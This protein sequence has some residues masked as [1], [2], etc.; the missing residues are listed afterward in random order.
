MPAGFSRERPKQSRVSSKVLSPRP[1]GDLRPH[2]SL[3][4]SEGDGLLVAPRDGDVC[5]LRRLVRLNGKARSIF[6]ALARG[7]RD[8]DVPSELWDDFARHGL[9]EASGQAI[10]AGLPEALG[11][12][13]HGERRLPARD[14][15][16]ASRAILAS[17]ARLRL[18]VLGRSMRPAL[19]NGS[20]IEVSATRPERLRRGDVLFYEKEEHP[21]VAHRL[22]SKRAGEWIT[23]GDSSTR[24]DVV[25][26]DDLYGRVVR[27]RRP[28][29]EWRE[30]GGLSRVKG[31]VLGV[32]CR[33]AQRTVRVLF[34]GPLQRSYAGPSRLRNAMRFCLR[35]AS[36]VL[37]RSER[38]ARRLR[39]PLDVARAGL[40]S[41]TEKD[42]DR[43]ELYARRSTQD[44]TS[45]DENV[46][47]GLT[48]IEEVLWAREG[49]RLGPPAR[50]LVLGCGPGRECFALARLGWTVTGLD[51]EAGM[52][53]RARGYGEEMGCDVRF[54]LGEAIQFDLTE[55][56]ELV[57]LFSGLYDMVLPRSRRVSMLASARDHLEPGG[58]V[59]LTFLSAY[60]DPKSP[61]PARARGFWE[62]ANRDH[63]AGDL[64]L[65]N[66]AVHLFRGAAEV[67][68]EATEAGLEVVAVH[69]DQRAYDRDHG[70]V[71]GYAVLRRA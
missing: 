20:W 69:R 31:L 71:K 62:A 32:V 48:L 64:Y 68:A 5:E 44:F 30:V 28:G 19:P 34:L 38:V 27:V 7:E 12:W 42:N 45:L 66:E 18:R 37:L 67:E 26:E 33:A 41:T 53:E 10:A 8:V 40:L 6:E 63:E 24:R 56:F 21:F 23:Y 47:A 54:I 13:S 1:A 61:P 57:V 16:R 39:R 65:L 35:G 14:L 36:G 46:R 9:A 70:Q 58:H 59:V 3:A 29:G 17:G 55:R 51:R 52:L 2:V 25:T 11:P 50:A 15:V 43:T 4:E 49:E 60:E 22:C